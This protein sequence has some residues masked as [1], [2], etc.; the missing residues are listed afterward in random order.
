ML[1]GL[2]TALSCLAD[3]ISLSLNGGGWSA[4]GHE[5]AMTLVVFNLFAK[6]ASVGLMY[7]IHEELRGLGTP[8]SS[9]DDDGKEEEIHF[10]SASPHQGSA[11]YQDIE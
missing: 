6:F 1:C 4:A 3:I 7:F 9:V 5:F 10:G 11:G 8:Y 2:I